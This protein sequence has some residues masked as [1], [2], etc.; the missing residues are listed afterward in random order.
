ME[1]ILYGAIGAFLGLLAGYL[2]GQRGKKVDSGL[3][4]VYPPKPGGGSGG[5]ADPPTIAQ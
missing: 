3:R 4:T 2:L 1:A 5:E